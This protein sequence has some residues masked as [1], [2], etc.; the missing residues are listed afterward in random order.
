VLV[1]ITADFC[2][3]L[4]VYHFT[5]ATNFDGFYSFGDRLFMSDSGDWFDDGEVEWSLDDESLG[6]GNDGELYQKRT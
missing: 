2:V 4:R 5:I 1:L 3:L 6:H